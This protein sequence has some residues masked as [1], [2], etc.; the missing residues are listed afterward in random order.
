[1][2]LLDTVKEFGKLDRAVSIAAARLCYALNKLIDYL[3]KINEDN[4]RG[5]I[6]V[7]TP[8]GQK[9]LGQF[10]MTPCSSGWKGPCVNG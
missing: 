2:S 8:I 6:K 3:I 1:M 9:L 7:S 10:L 4:V 5:S